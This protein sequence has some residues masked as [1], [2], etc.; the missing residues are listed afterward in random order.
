MIKILLFGGDRLKEDVPLTLVADHLTKKKIKFIIITDKSRLNKSSKKSGTFKNLLKRKKYKFII[1]DKLNEKKVVSLID[2]DTFGL[3]LNSTWKFKNKLINSFRGNFY[4]YHAADMPQERGSGNISWKILKKNIKT[5]SINIHVIDQ[6]FD[7][8]D[9][10]AKKKILFPNK[11]KGILPVDFLKKIAKNEKDLLIN[12]VDKMIKKKK[13]KK[14]KQNHKKSFYWPRL[15]ADK[16]GCI[17]WSWNAKEIISFI[18]AFSKP[19][20]GAFTFLGKSKI[21]IYNAHINSKKE[22]F[23]PFQNGL[24]FRKDKKS[25]YVAN[26]KGSIKIRINNISFKNEKIKF[27]G[28][29]FN[30]FKEK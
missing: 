27:L 1:F 12:F 18:R 17:N 16:D 23:H 6:E 19:Y 10:V 14:I 11:K 4:N 21:R 9:I 28:K 29:R 2:K 15:N 7:T 30:S 8:G 26:Q 13:F 3:S 24:I 20:N 5:G 22:K 25:I